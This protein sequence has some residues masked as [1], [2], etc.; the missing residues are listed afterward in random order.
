MCFLRKSRTNQ[1]TKHTISSPME[2]KTIDVRVAL[3]SIQV[4]IQKIKLQVRHV[5]IIFII[6]INK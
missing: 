2:Q 3:L 4:I 6:F 1:A 5:M